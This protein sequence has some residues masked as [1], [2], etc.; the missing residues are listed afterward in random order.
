MGNVY[1]DFDFPT[2]PWDRGPVPRGVH[3]CPS[4]RYARG[5]GRDIPVQL[6]EAGGV[7]GY[8]S[9]GSFP[10]FYITT[11]GT[12]IYVTNNSDGTRCRHAKLNN[13][14]KPSS[15]FMFG[16][17]YNRSQENVMT[18]T[19]PGSNSYY[20]IMNFERHSRSANV[21]HLD[22][23]TAN[24]RFGSQKGLTMYSDSN[25]YYYSH[26]CANWWKLNNANYGW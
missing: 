21:V 20:Q 18:A 19:W 2:Q 17:I 22:G 3:L 6:G 23:H 7:L 25:S 13:I 9:S 26:W 16:D 1:K 11:Y 14:K 8:K 10:R 15:L 5:P 12:N 24:Y 4:E